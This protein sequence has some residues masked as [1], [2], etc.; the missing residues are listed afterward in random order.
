MSTCI[1]LEA[2][3]CRPLVIV[4]VGL[5]S[6]LGVGIS[7]SGLHQNHVGSVRLRRDRRSGVR[8]KKLPEV[9][10]DELRIVHL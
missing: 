2:V 4:S 3:S 8:A 6:L 9:L 5:D 7:G 10:A 1:H